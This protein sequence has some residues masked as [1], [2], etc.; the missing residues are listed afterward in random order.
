MANFEDK[1]HEIY[2]SINDA[3]K[4]IDKRWADK[5]LRKK[6]EDFFSGIIPHV[7]QHEPRAILCR[8]IIS[9]DHEMLHFLKMAS[10]IH[11]KPLGLEG[12]DDIFVT[13][14][15]D[16]MCL[17]KM[18]FCDNENPVQYK[19]IINIKENEG[20]IFSEIKTL[21][22]ENLVDFHHRL[23][24]IYVPNKIEIFDDLKWYK[25]QFNKST[26]AK[27]YYKFYLAFF[28]CYGVLFENFTMIG[29]EASFTE[30]TFK[31]AY[32][33]IIKNFGVKPLIVPAIPANEIEDKYWWCYPLGVKKTTD[34]SLRPTS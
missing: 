17:V 8:N 5:V 32:D 23:L 12:I 26:M 30:K 15:P 22:G 28:V 20:K 27:D 34:T 1:H 31:P 4:E 10:K 9:P 2:T 19:T 3:K 16:K 25:K 33:F 6:I 24:D 14:N 11:L 21:W 18:A 13:I 7:F 29:K